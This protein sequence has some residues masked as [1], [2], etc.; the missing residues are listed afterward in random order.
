[1]KR[2]LAL[3]GMLGAAIAVV[4]LGLAPFAVGRRYDQIRLGMTEDQVT[5]TL[6]AEPDETD[7]YDPPEIGSSAGKPLMITRQCRWHMGRATIGVAFDAQG[8]AVHRF[9]MTPLRRTGEPDYWLN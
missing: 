3:F 9:L 8:R 2:W 6:N 5:A 1:M 4:A 7:S